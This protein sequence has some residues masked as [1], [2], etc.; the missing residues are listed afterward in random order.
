MKKK[1]SFLMVALVAV[2]A[3]A[4][5]VSRRAVAELTVVSEATVWDFADV[6]LGS[7]YTGDFKLEGDAKNTENI[8]ANFE[9]ITFAPTFKADALAFTGEYPVRS[10][11]KKFAQ[12]GTL[13]FKTSVAGKIVVKFSDTGSSA[14]ATAVKRYLVVNGTQTEYWTSRENNGTESPYAAQMNVE[15]GEIDVP[16]GDVTITGSSAIVVTYVAFT[17]NAA[18][19]GETGGEEKTYSYTFEKKVFDAVGEKTLNEVQWTLATDGGYFGFDSQ[20]GKGQQFGSGS[21]PAKATTL[22]TSGIPGTIKSVKVNASGANGIE[23]TVG[24]TVNGVAFKCNEAESV[25]LTTTATDYEFVGSATGA[26]AINLAQT[27]SKAVYIKS[28]EVKY[29]VAGGE[30]PADVAFTANWNWGTGVPATLA[31]VHIENTTGTVA[32][33]VEGVELTVDATSGKFKANGDNVQFNA[34]TKIQVPVKAVGDKVTVV[35]HPYNFAKIKVGGEESTNQTTVRYAR[36]WEVQAGYVEIES[37]ESPYLISIQLDHVLYAFPEEAVWSG[38]FPEWQEGVA[39]EAEAFANLKAGDE[40]EVVQFANMGDG[41]DINIKCDGQQMLWTNFGEGMAT[42]FIVTGA[43]VKAIK[44]KGLT[45]NVQ[46]MAVYMK[47]NAAAVAA[48]ENSVW[49][50]EQ[51]LGAWEGGA[52]FEASVLSAI[53]AAA[54]KVL[55]IKA[56]EPV[57]EATAR[58][59]RALAGIEVHLKKSDWAEFDPVVKGIAVA[60]GFIFPLTDAV[61]EEINT[62]GFKIQANSPLVITELDV[63]DIPATDITIAPTEGDIAAALATAASAEGVLKVGKIT[64]NL[65]EGVTY[66]VS[67]SLVAPNSITINGNGAIIDASALEGN[68]IEFAA[69]AAEDTKWT[70]ADVAITAVTVKGLKKALFYSN[71]KFYYGNFT[72]INSFIEQAADA[73]TFDY[74][75][76]STALNFTI[77][78]STIY[79]PTATT[80]SLYSSQGGQKATEYNADATQNFL[81]SL[82]TMYNLAKGKNFFTHRQNSQKWLSY[83]VQ[84][85]IFVDCGKSGQVIKGL[86]GG[87]SSAN[88]TW[89]VKGNAFN[90]DGA[91]TS[92]NEETGD[93]DHTQDETPGLNETVQNSV[94]GLA[95]FANAAE[96]DF[97]LGFDC[98]QYAAKI[99][100]PRW[101]KEN[102]GEAI[103]LNPETGADLYTALAAAMQTNPNPASITINLAEN[104]AYTIT[105]SLSASKSI[106][107][108]G[109]GA[110][111][112]ASNCAVTAETTTPVPFIQMAAL[113]GYGLN[114][115]GAYEVAEISFNNV[116]ITGLKAQLFYANKQKYL[117]KK[118]AVDNSIIAI[119]G[120]T[121]KTIFDFNGGGNVVELSVANS[122]IWADAATTWQNGGF[123]SSQGGQDAVSL[124]A[125]NQKTSIVNSTIYNIAKGVTTS[126]R[127]KN[128]QKWMVYEVKNN[129]IVNS[130]KSGQFL[131]GLNAGQAGNAAN[132]DVKNN[133]FNFE[134][135]GALTDVS[136]TAETGEAAKCKNAA[137]PQMVEGVVEFANAAEGDFTLA[138]ACAQNKAKIG[139]PRWLV[140]APIEKLYLIGDINSWKLNEM[141]EM[142]FNEETQAF[143][144]EYAPTGQVNFSV[145]D[146]MFADGDWD[147]FKAGHRFALGEGNKTPTLGEEVQLVS[148][149][150]G[151]IQ[152]QAGK[153]K[154]SVTK[155]LKMTITA[156]TDGISEMKANQNNAVIYNLNGVRVDKAQKG[157]YIV[158]GKKVVIK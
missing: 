49:I 60:D 66:T 95:A 85:N 61:A 70:N 45:V 41:A 18:E 111:V 72:L 117:I 26:I 89:V 96:G 23:G 25:A 46:K 110:T 20:N 104:G 91:D 126:T 63:I 128:S 116:K 15:T 76:G 39:I 151:N 97:T 132:W 102:I 157:L 145:A 43:M 146:Q 134:V 7:S 90:F 119:A 59:N 24:V 3:F 4:V 130:G 93:T 71:S 58:G 65:T 8:Y 87:G 143:E 53:P 113:P 27:S 158:N 83:T 16:A 141:V 40:I 10:N 28:I 86:N 17:P 135:E 42:K 75:K 52:E 69:K 129:V 38:V 156:K 108:N 80:K 33:D 36:A 64:I 29:E 101:L 34:G 78:G 92:T 138:A 62:N 155:D 127:R 114:A 67:A 137:E 19:G 11:S 112:D 100:D 123:Y 73:T 82:N 30:E 51:T 131:I 152:L 122:T 32:S 88:P 140:A 5:Q 21:A 1:L 106:I 31:N 136:T 79:A 37:V 115:K 120:A 98:A 99:G 103:V 125:E 57:V 35:A 6:T 124:G 22:S 142:T 44:E 153:Y 150:E 118:L 68:M 56:H 74:T 84:N 47:I 144:Y 105:N 54:D 109:N 94:A 154:I 12:S 147:G 133:S 107:I 121:K 149:V 14:S 139:D 13:H 148:V 2:A 77:E 9:D 48:D 55:K 81:F 50:G